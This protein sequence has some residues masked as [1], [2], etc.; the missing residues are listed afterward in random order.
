MKPRSTGATP[1]SRKQALGLRH[2]EHLR[3]LSE[4]AAAH[5]EPGQRVERVVL[6]DHDEPAGARDARQL[7]HE[8]RAL[9]RREYLHDA[10]REREVKLAVR[11]RK[12]V[13]LGELVADAG[14]GARGCLE[15]AGRDVRA[16]ERREPPGEVAVGEPDAAA[17]VER[18]ELRGI[19]QV[20]RGEPNELVGLR[21]GEEVVVGARERDCRRRARPCTGLGTGRSRSSAVRERQ[22]VDQLAEPRGVLVP[23]GGSELDVRP[24][25][26]DL[27]IVVPEARFR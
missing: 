27:G 5:D 17:D 24:L 3:V 20:Q 25:D 23:L 15:H 1:F 18:D 19:A 16:D 7:G 13:A 9:R 22:V 6:E 12:A 2:P 14:I 11:E 4:L 8:A 26:P 10:D 21:A